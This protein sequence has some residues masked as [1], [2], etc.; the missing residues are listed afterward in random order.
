MLPKFAANL[1]LLYTEVP[2]LE[3]FSKAS[4]RGFTAVEFHFPYDNDINEIKSRLDNLG[5]Q[6]VLFNLHP[7]DVDNNEWGTL[8]NP[9]RQDY[10]RWSLTTALDIANQ[11]HC[12][13]INVMFGN[14]VPGLMEEDQL[15]C[16]LDNLA[17]AAKEARENRVTLL[18]EAL[19][20][21]DFPIVFLQSPTAALE[22]VKS[23][24]H[25]NVKLLYDVYHAQMT[26]GN[27]INSIRD[28]YPFINHIQI[29]DVPGRHEPGTGEIDYPSIFATLK[30]LG[31]QGFVGLEYRPSSSTDASLGWFT[32]YQSR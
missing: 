19:N 23:I 29:A 32:K 1:S 26:E 8:S 12:N 5:L 6:L 18:I 2:F 24:N 14:K 22:V 15:Q 17:W 20:P 9:G 25:P 27:L 30:V 31:Y 4:T 3:R 11:L 10:F 28:F 21:Y 7:G 13:Q 16:A